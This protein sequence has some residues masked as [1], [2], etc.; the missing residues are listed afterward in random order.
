MEVL[1]PPS[2]NSEMGASGH[3]A[4]YETKNYS[5]THL[6][7]FFW[8][9]LSLHVTQQNGVIGFWAGGQGW[10]SK[11]APYKG[12]VVR[13]SESQFP[14]GHWYRLGSPSASALSG[15]CP[16]GSSGAALPNFSGWFSPHPTSVLVS[17]FLFLNWNLT[18]IYVVRRGRDQKE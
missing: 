8:L 17:H 6:P 11:W 5:L 12:W 9:N 15:F 2:Q 4:L 1:P 3:V 14:C 13:P 18:V 10:G 7:L 16:R